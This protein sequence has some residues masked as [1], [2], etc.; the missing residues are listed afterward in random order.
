M[1]DLSKQEPHYAYAQ[2]GSERPK[3]T[4][5]YFLAEA[6]TIRS[7]V[8]NPEELAHV[9][10]SPGVWGNDGIFMTRHDSTIF[11]WFP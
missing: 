1:S 7:T 3:R 9:V 5:S 10:H 4:K 2:L 6:I 8:I 11:I